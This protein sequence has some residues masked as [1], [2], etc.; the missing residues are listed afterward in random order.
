MKKYSYYTLLIFS[1]MLCFGDNQAIP[2]EGEASSQ[3]PSFP[4]QEED[5]KEPPLQESS[6]ESQETGSPSW[7][8]PS[9]EVI[10]TRPPIDLSQSLSGKNSFDETNEEA[11][12]ELEKLIQEESS[13]KEVSG[14]VIKSFFDKLGVRSLDQGHQALESINNFLREKGQSNALGNKYEHILQELI[15]AFTPHSSRTWAGVQSLSQNSVDPTFSEKAAHKIRELGGKSNTDNYGHPEYDPRTLGAMTMGVTPQDAG[16]DM[17]QLEEQEVLTQ[18][19]HQSQE[20]LNSPEPKEIGNGLVQRNSGSFM[21]EGTKT[22]DPELEWEVLREGQVKEDKEFIEKVRKEIRDILN[23]L[24]NPRTPLGKKLAYELDKVYASKKDKQKALKTVLSSI[25]KKVSENQLV[26]LVG[27]HFFKDKEIVAAMVIA[28]ILSD[29]SGVPITGAAIAVY[30]VIKF[31]Y[32]RISQYRTQQAAIQEKK[33]KV[34][35][36]SQKVRKFGDEVIKAYPEDQEAFMKSAIRAFSQNDSENLDNLVQMN[37]QDALKSR[38]IK[39]LGDISAL[40]EQEI[41]ERAVRFIDNVID[42]E[43]K[44]KQDIV[45]AAQMIF[46]EDELTDPQQINVE[47]E[48]V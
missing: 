5:S 28:R 29:S 30:N 14:Q 24:E 37:D 1:G 17:T 13:R 32:S 2:L 15:G 34:E 43:P 20:F 22:F 16:K 4:F 47:A 42:E 12:S 25:W 38:Y 10:D 44:N 3:N 40:P 35:S 11:G 27:S 48:A 23:N 36:L 39:S 6:A 46:N 19:D 26:Q 7:G 8:E 41:K 21:E 45:Q 33:E 18:L 31:F 9:V